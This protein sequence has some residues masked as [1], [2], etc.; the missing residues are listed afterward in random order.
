M[1]K[2]QGTRKGAIR[3]YTFGFFVCLAGFL[4]GYDTGVS[5]LGETLLAPIHR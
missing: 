1:A 2:L 3:A 4:F 5:S